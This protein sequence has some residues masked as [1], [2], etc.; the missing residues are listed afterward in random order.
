MRVEDN[1]KNGCKFKILCCLPQQYTRAY[2]NDIWE[3]AQ[4]V[5]K[6]KATID[7]FPLG[8]IHNMI[9]ALKCYPYSISYKGENRK[10]ELF[11]LLI[12][13]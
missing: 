5:K 8:F 1:Q 9:S 4:G 7:I 10:F 12:H 11:N 2:G 3:K 6:F 13:L